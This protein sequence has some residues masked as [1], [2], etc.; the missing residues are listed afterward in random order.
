MKILFVC[1][2][3]VGRSQMAEAIFNN[4][5]SDHVATSA[6]LNPPP[7]WEG[8]RLLKTQYVAPCMAEISI[9]VSEKV[10]KRLNEAMVADAD[11]IIVIGEPNNW[12]TFLTLSD[13]VEYWDITDPDGTDLDFT[14]KVR[15]EIRTRVENLIEIF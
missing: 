12:P 10:S 11:K 5:S 7:Q 1:R 6:G 13:K 2:A 9:D 8:E 14:R 4:L 15:D 3:N